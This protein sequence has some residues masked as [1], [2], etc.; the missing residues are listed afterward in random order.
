M[1]R[2][3]V[4]GTLKR[5]ERNECVW[6]HRPDAIKAGTV[7]GRLYDMGAFPAMVLPAE[8]EECNDR[9]EG[10]VWSFSNAAEWG[11]VLARLDRLEGYRNDG[12]GLYKRNYV[13]VDVGG[14]TIPALAYNMTEER[15]RSWNGTP[16]AGDG[17]VI[18][19]T[20]KAVV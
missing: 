15:M 18:R 10:E 4:Y 20:G 17:S 1:N 14:R 6:P 9:V 8:G 7:A 11:A 2:I 3:F 12:K 19:W 5:G 13:Q 16:I